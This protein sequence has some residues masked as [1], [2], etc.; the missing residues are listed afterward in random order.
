MDKVELEARAK[1]NLTLDVLYKRPDGYHEVEMIMQ[2]ISLKDRIVIT[3]LPGRDIRI[4]NS[5]RELPDGEDNLAFKAAKLM[6]DEFG[7]DAG[8]EIKLFKEIP[9]AA[10]L[11]GGSADAAAVLEGLNELFGLRLSKE[12]LMRLGER[13]GADVPFCS[14]GGTALARGKGEQLTPLPPVP[15]MSLL[16]VKPPF[17]VST[18]EV[19]SR[20]NI[21]SIKKRPDTEAVIKSI[22]KGDVDGISQGLCNVLE[23]VTFAQHP[24]LEIIKAWLVERGALGSLMSG[25]GPTV[26]GIFE[27]RRDAE[28]AAVSVPPGCRIFITQVD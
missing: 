3:L 7:L 9:I 15:P 18:K 28:R 27:N 16:L 25:S 26:Y 17:A 24:E 22:E 10:G 13:I 5:C 12:A 6:M 21:K 1:I 11:A 20:L 8:V 19:Y 14:M 4:V 23:E 2:T